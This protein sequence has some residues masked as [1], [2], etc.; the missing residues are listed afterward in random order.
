[1]KDQGQIWTRALIEIILTVQV[2]KNTTNDKKYSL[3]K[4]VHV[5]HLQSTLNTVRSYLHLL[6]LCSETCLKIID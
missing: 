2:A 3:K 6:H 1:M 4:E 5:N